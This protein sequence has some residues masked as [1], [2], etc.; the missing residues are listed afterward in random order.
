MLGAPIDVRALLHR[1]L[2]LTTFFL[3]LTVFIMLHTAVELFVTVQS[4]SLDAY[5]TS[6]RYQRGVWSWGHSYCLEE[7]LHSIDGDRRK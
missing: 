1:H 6:L 2:W 3:T 7:I 4:K 5:C